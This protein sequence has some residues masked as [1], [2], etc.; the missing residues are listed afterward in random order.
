LAGGLG[1]I[2]FSSAMTVAEAAR[3]Y[4]ADMQAAAEKIAVG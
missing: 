4:V 2:F 1:L 3:R